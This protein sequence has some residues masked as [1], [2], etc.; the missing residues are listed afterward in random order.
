MINIVKFY[1]DIRI[2]FHEASSIF[3]S[4]LKNHQW[5]I[6][7]TGSNINNAQTGHNCAMHV[8]IF[9]CFCYAHF[10]RNLPAELC[11]ETGLTCC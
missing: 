5:S 10:G 9:C 7:S 3:Y 2:E 1:F 6:V 4:K 11:D 8:V